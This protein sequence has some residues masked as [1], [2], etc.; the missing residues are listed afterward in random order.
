MDY[1]AHETAIIDEGCEIFIMPA[2]FTFATGKLHWE[3][4]IKARA[5]ENQCYFIAS[6]QSGLHENGRETWGHS[7]IVSDAGVIKKELTSGIG[8]VLDKINRKEQIK[9]RERFPV[10]NHR[11]L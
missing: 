7:M 5:I 2:A 10:L 1:F 6:A 4:L 11:K 8:F 3:A 9:T